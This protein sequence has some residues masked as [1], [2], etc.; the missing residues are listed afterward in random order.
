MI[1]LSPTDLDWFTQLRDD[2]SYAQINFWTP[3][4]WNIR[5]LKPGDRFYF[6]LK[7]P[8]R[9]IGG[10]GEFAV[11]ENLTASQAWERFGTANGVR[12][13]MELVTRTTG[14]ARRHSNQFELHE[15]PTIGCILLSNPVFLDDGAFL[16]PEEAGLSFPPEVVKL[17][18]F[19]VPSITAIQLPTTGKEPFQ[20]V[21][22]GN[23]TYRETRVSERSGQSAFRQ[24]V[25]EA[26]GYRCAITGE[27][28]REVLEAAHIQPYVNEES[29]D[30]RNG[31][32][33]RTD[34]HRLFDA[35]LITVDADYRVQVSDHLSSPHYQAHGGIRLRLPSDPGKHPA[36]I[37]LD[38]HRRYVYRRTAAY[39]RA[40][41]EPA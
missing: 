37:S 16:S 21:D 29:N 6:L 8:I 24:M 17:K 13:L 15:D 20:L 7:A 36:S 10:Y 9:K 34:I 27:T 4:P 22:P 33:L 30:V 3:T 31:L 41:D 19:P 11:Y 35:G 25:L 32:A 5:Q 1:A 2:P 39:P 40:R 12:S 26:Y 28:C 38:F 18:Y 23:K 14:Y